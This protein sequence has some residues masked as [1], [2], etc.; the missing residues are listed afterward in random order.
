MK[1]TM[2]LLVMILFIVAR[3]LASYSAEN[4]PAVSERYLPQEREKYENTMEK[5]LMKLGKQL[6]KINAKAAILTEQTRKD[7]NRYLDDAK[8]KQ[9]KGLRKLQEIRNASTDKWKQLTSEMDA[10]ADSF[11]KAYEKAKSYVKD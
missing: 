6:D 7:M 11:E 2:L 5:R 3:P 4:E 1:L 10:A 9:K 8:K